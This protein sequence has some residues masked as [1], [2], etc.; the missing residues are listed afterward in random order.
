MSTTLPP[1][2]LNNHVITMLIAIRDT[3]PSAMY[4]PWSGRILPEATQ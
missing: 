2:W 3:L 4:R 1:V